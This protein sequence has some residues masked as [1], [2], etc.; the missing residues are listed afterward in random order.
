MNTECSPRITELSP[1]EAFA[2][3]AA[4]RLFGR[5]RSTRKHPAVRTARS[6]SPRPIAPAFAPNNCHDSGRKDHDPVYKRAALLSPTVRG[7]RHDRRCIKPHRIYGEGRGRPT[8]TRRHS[9]I[10]TNSD[11]GEA[12]CEGIHE[13]VR[14]LCE[15]GAVAEIA[16]RPPSAQARGGASA[17][18]QSNSRTS[19]EAASNKS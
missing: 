9:E 4:Q 8:H 17:S 13:V 2:R 12:T 16:P 14:Y 7:H 6:K 1:R 19:A 3:H 11:S 10:R 15:N 18:K 5:Y